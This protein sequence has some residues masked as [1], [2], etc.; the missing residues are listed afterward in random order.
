MKKTI[1][2]LLLMCMMLCCG[3]FAFAI[4]L[5]EHLDEDPSNDPVISE[6]EASESVPENYYIDLRL[7]LEQQLKN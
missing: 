2:L 1:A 7:I 6:G 4:M 5:P 3:S